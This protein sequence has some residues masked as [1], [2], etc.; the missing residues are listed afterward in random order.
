MGDI[1]VRAIQRYGVNEVYDV[2]M[3]ESDILF[4]TASTD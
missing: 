4:N 2:C 1:T 3:V